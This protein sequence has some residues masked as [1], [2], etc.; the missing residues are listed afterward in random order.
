MNHCEKDNEQNPHIEVQNPHIEVQNPHIEVQNPHIEVQ[1]PHIEVQNPHSEVLSPEISTGSWLVFTLKRILDWNGGPLHDPPFRFDATKEAAEFNFDVLKR[2]NFCLEEILAKS[3]LSPC[4]FGSEF[5]PVEILEPLFEFHERWPSMKNILRNGSQFIYKENLSPEVLLKDLK[6]Q[7]ERGNHKSAIRE[8]KVLGKAMKKE[9]RFGFQLPLLPHHPLEIPEARMAPM[10]VADQTSINERGEIISKQ[11]VTH[12]QSFPGEFSGESVNSMI[13]DDYLEP[14]TFGHAHSRLLH[15]IVATRIKFPNARILGN[16]GDFKSA[17]RRLHFSGKAAIHS[18]TQAEIDGEDFTLMPLRCTFGGKVCPFHWCGISEPIVDLTNALLECEDW[19]PYELHSPEQYDV[20][21]PSYLGDDIPLEAG[22]ELLV[23]V[24]V[25]ES[26]RA[27]GY[28]DDIPTFGPDLGPDHRAKLAAATFLAIHAVGRDL[29]DESLPRDCLLSLDKLAAE[30]GLTELLVVLGWLYDTRR[31]R[32]SLPEHKYTAWKNS[33]LEMLKSGSALPK[34]LES[35]INRL[36]HMAGVLKGSRHF[37]S[38]LRYYFDQSKEVESKKYTRIHFNKTTLEDLSLMLKFLDKAHEGVSM[39]ILVFR[40]PNRIYRTDACEYGLGGIF[41]DNSLWRWIIPQHLLHRAHITL[42]E[43]L[44][45]IVPVWMD[46]LDGLLRPQDCFLS[47]GDNSNAVAWMVNS[48]FKLAEED[49]P[50]QQAKLRASRKL[51]SL[52]MDFS[53]AQFSQWMC[54]DDNVIPDI[55]SRDLHLLENELIDN[56][57][58]FISSSHPTKDTPQLRMRKVHKEIDSFLC[59]V[60]QQLPKNPQRFTQHKT[61]GFEPGKD[62]HSSFHPSALKAMISWKHLLQVKRL[63]S[64]QPSASQ[65]EKEISQKIQQE[66]GPY[67][68]PYNMYRRPSKLR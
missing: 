50:D 59:S 8:K 62:G 56:L 64:S 52:V 51:A 65:S 13:D 12:D 30:G 48:N 11:R 63:P 34:E 37:L 22:R 41:Q 27:D 39:N 31:L 29:E 7:M 2:N 46:I 1:N 6:A 21:P 16:K 4:H 20:P 23:N 57:T 38:R 68:I 66:L 32:V 40:S 44:G 19:N 15:Y 5:K 26:G 60:L 36:S 10:G 53:L 35:L 47:L 33:V 18:L 54:G 58:H 3:P 55:C 67:G 24:P 43:F 49:L 61:S 28:I 25:D 17:Y 45:M 14:L 9:V 42:L